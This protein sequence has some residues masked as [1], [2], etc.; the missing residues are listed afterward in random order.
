MRAWGPKIQQREGHVYARRETLSGLY[1][2][3]AISSS[4]LDRL[5]LLLCSSQF[6]FNSVSLFEVPG[7]TYH[8]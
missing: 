6:R 7:S 3:L 8:N 2:G 1:R 5:A 4:V